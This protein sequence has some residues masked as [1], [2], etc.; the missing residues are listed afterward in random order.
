MKLVARVYL[1]WL[2]AEQQCICSQKLLVS[3]L[4]QRNLQKK[5]FIR[6]GKSCPWFMTNS[7]LSLNITF[8]LR[9][10][11][12]KISISPWFLALICMESVRNKKTYSRR[13]IRQSIRH[14]W[15][16]TRNNFCFYIVPASLIILHVQKW[17]TPLASLIIAFLGGRLFIAGWTSGL[18]NTYIH[19]GVSTL[20]I[21]FSNDLESA[22]VA[23]PVEEPLQIDRNLAFA[24]YLVL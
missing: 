21:S 13:I 8:H 24:L 4:L 23:P 9:R 15:T 16:G 6:D 11:L 14:Y 2:R 19:D 22:I 1:S 12:W 18:A 10:S 3:R 17:K 20:S 7:L 5:M